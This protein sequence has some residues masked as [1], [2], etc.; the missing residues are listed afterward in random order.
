MLLKSIDD[1]NSFLK[2]YYKSPSCLYGS[3][4]PIDEQGYDAVKCIYF[5]EFSEGTY[6]YSIVMPIH[7]QEAIIIDNLK[8]I[9]NFTV[10]SN[11]IILILDACDDNTKDLVIELFESLIDYKDLRRVIICSSDV[12]LFETICDNIGFRLACGKWF[13]E[14]QADMTMV[15]MGY[16]LRLTIPF[17]LSNSIIAVSGRCCHNIIETES[18]GKYYQ[19][20]EKSVHQLGIDRNFFYVNEVCNRGPLL[21]SASK[22]REMGY[23]DETN[24]FL[25][26]SE[27]DL[28]LRAYDKKEWICGYVPIDFF[29]PLDHGSTRKPRNAKNT[30]IYNV[31]KARSNGGFL[32]KY[33]ERKIFRNVYAVPLPD[34]FTR[35]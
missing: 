16:N 5:K 1:V 18:I 17:Y 15:E 32:K 20:I 30:E 10:G 21:L 26:Y 11:E 33:I 25:D 8:S 3:P 29:S 28:M 31:R 35:K 4:K 14:I 13:L 27:M 23:L 24:F 12:P 9:L 34:I 7:N 19:D 6:D 22:T 2:S